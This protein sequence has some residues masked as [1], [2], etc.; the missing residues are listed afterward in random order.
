MPSN[1]MNTGTDYSIS[2]YEGNSGAL[3]PITDVQT[4]KIT[5]LKHEIKSQ[6][7]NGPPRYAF[8]P[9]GY[10]IDFTIV[11]T[12]SVL[13]DLAVLNEA[14]FNNGQIMSPG[15]FQQTTTNPDG[16]ISRFQYTNFVVWLDEHGDVARDKTTTQTLTG[17]ASTKTP[18]A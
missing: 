4:A 15:V 3:V 16:S 6:P 11:R 2:Y 5:A 18:I 14:N 17:Y 9:D 13:E 1:G 7:F 12:G 10:K 8:V